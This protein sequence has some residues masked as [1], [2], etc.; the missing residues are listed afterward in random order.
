MSGIVAVY[1]LDGR[2]ADR[3][4]IT[5]MLDVAAYRGPGGLNSWIDGPVALGHAMLRTT[6]EATNESQPLVDEQAGLALTMDG[7]VD[8]RD[9]LKAMLE[10]QGLRLAG[11]TD[12]EIVLRAYQCWG[13][14][15]PAKILGDFAFAVW[16]AGKRRLFCARDFASVQPLFYYCDGRTFICASEPQQI[17]VDPAVPREPDERVIGMYLTGVLL[18]P[19]ATLYRDIRKLEGGCSMMV[20]PGNSGNFANSGNSGTS[21]KSGRIDR[22]RFFDIN[23]AKQIRYRTDA[24]YA[25]HF[26]SLFKE[27]VRC[28][29]RNVDG[30]AAELSGGL[31]SSLVVGTAQLMFRQGVLPAPRFET[32]SIR[33]DDDPQADE[34]GFIGDVAAMWGLETNWSPAFY[35]K[36]PDFLADIRRYRGF[37]GR[38]NFTMDALMHR[39][40]RER[41][42]RVVLTGQGGDQWFSGSP[43]C[44]A[45]LLCNFRFGE[46]I[47]LLR[48]EAAHPTRVL[49]GQGP[50]ALLIRRTLWPLVPA[51]P[52]FLINCMRGVSL[53]P[54]FVNRKFARKLDLERARNTPTR[55][56]RGLDFSQRTM[57]QVL[58]LGISVHLAELNER[59]CAFAGLEG[60]HPFYDRR[61]IE[62]AFA[63]PEDQ[64]CRPHATKFIMR[65]AGRSVL[66]ESVRQRRDK[67][68][69]SNMLLHGLREVTTALGGEAAFDSLNVVQRGWVDPEQLR[70]VYEERM[71]DPAANQWPLWSVMELEMWSR[72]F[73]AGGV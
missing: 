53:V 67:A 20:R 56:I 6:P 48:A 50:L 38:P 29:L 70:R 1:Y 54:P 16:D 46:L 22:R 11:N 23:P 14:E 63:I 55:E 62:F 2:P 3:G 49:S 51:R 68:E 44:F 33:F 69:F 52:K 35:A 15:S 32:F 28:R 34:R 61:I 9:E 66:P 26:E 13:E 64:R 37:S 10:R 4:L 58:N 17:L 65:E 18:D 47:R 39:A 45:D 42:Y 36:Y 41:G 71:A 31:D 27:A 7:R 59:E 12:A 72:E 19:A 24:E 73:L 57:Y 8:N 21:S 5:A 40:M 30:V 60:R 43:D 25:E